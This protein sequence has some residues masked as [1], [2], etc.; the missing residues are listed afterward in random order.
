MPAGDYQF[1]VGVK[2]DPFDKSADPKIVA[3]E[4]AVFDAR[5]NDTQILFDANTRAMRR[6]RHMGSDLDTVLEQLEAQGKVPGRPPSITPIYSGEALGGNVGSGGCPAS[7]PGSNPKCAPSE[8]G[9]GAPYQAKSEKLHRM[10]CG[11]S[12]CL[13][14]NG[15]NKT[16]M[17][18]FDLYTAMSTSPCEYNAT[19]PLQKAL[20]ALQATGQDKTVWTLNAGDEI[21]LKGGDLSNSSFQAYL[22]AN[23]VSLADVGCSAWPQCDM[24]TLDRVNASQSRAT[25]MLFYHTQVYTWSAALD[26][27]A[28]KTA[29]VTKVMKHA[30]IGP[31]LAPIYMDTDP[32]RQGGGAGPFMFG[33]A[34][35][36]IGHTYQSVRSFR[37]KAI[38]LPWT[39]DYIWPAPVPSQ[40][41]MT[42]TYDAFRSG[43]LWVDQPIPAA[44][45][46]ASGAYTRIPTPK[47]HVRIHAYVMPHFPGNTWRSWQRQL[48]GD[49]AHGATDIDLFNLV[50]SFSGY[51]CDYADSDGGIYPAVRAAFNMLGS[52]EDIVQAGAVQAQGAAVALLYSETSDV[53]VD[54]HTPGAAMRSLYL[55]LRHAELPVDIV[56]EGDCS[57]GLLY[58][59]HALYIAFPQIST[60][61]SKGIASWVASGGTVVVGSNAALLNEAN[62]SNTDMEQLLGIKPAGLWMGNADWYNS[63]VQWVKQDLNFVELLDTAT[64]TADTAAHFGLEEA[65]NTMAVKG[66]KSIFTVESKADSRTLATFK[67]GSAAAIKTRRGQG[68]AFYF[69]F[70]VGLAYYAPAVPLRPVDRSSVDEGMSHTILTEMNVVAKHLAALPLQGVEGAVPVNSSNPLVEV[71]IITAEGKGTAMPCINWSGGPI[72]DF[73]ITLNFDL[74]FTNVTLASEGGVSVSADRRTVSFSLGETIDAVI[75]R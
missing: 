8:K 45:P 71:G 15:D 11:N 30:K 49:I 23:G 13:T 37:E 66:G 69:G 7:Q 2:D 3:L 73:R 6:A 74:Q 61:A 65:D 16:A 22:Q 5:E 31:N 17:G 44:P 47:K 25:A 32:A 52:F 10:F 75:F 21:Q 35:A 12:G 38:T 63:S 55:A 67:D 9:R 60:N 20:A 27:W 56:I 39:E 54:V 34:R 72:A 68:H 26:C 1:T 50:P 70:H 46:N 18:Y 36:Y 40:Q 62:R 42:M 33:G 19:S 41:I 29:Q 28:S 51:T 59:Y 53:W 4:D 58:H 48:F 43:L 57:S 14:N 24:S 64:L